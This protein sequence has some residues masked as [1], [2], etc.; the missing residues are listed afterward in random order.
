MEGD[1]MNCRECKEKISLYIDNELTDKE[2]EEFEEHLKEC[3]NCRVEF[4]N[5]KYI[6]ETVKNIPLEKLPE[7][8][9]EKLHD[10]LIENKSKNRWNWKRM[11]AIAATF[12]ILLGATYIFS[13]AGL[14]GGKS[15][16]DM[17]FMEEAAE[18][19]AFPAEGQSVDYEEAEYDKALEEEMGFSGT[20]DV[21]RD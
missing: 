13:N 12:V 3:D 7:G 20:G 15:S 4:E 11:T 8:Y 1:F 19:P 5:T 9:C 21:G 2:A 6:I 18:E 14:G 10:K 16:N 17:G